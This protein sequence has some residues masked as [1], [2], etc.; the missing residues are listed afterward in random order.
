VANAA[1]FLL[2]ESSSGINGSTLTIDA[3]LGANYFD[4]EIIRLAMRPA[5]QPLEISNPKTPNAK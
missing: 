1:V 2:S 5:A 4:Q 3:G